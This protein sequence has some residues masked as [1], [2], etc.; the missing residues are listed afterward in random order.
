[1]RLMELLAQLPEIF[2]R[3]DFSVV[4]AE[5]NLHGIDH[6][7]ESQVSH[8]RHMRLKFLLILNFILYLI[9]FL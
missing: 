3:V 1:M 2:L 7:I 9:D 4:E 6:G 5:P 8:A